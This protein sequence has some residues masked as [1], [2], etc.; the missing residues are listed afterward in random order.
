VFYFDG[1]DLSY[2]AEDR[3]IRRVAA[4]CAD[5]PIT[6]EVKDQA[7]VHLWYRRRLRARL[8]ET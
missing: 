3:V 4:A 8:P 1:T 5:L 6:I 7:R 2:E